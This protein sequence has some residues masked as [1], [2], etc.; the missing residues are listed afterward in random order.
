MIV[1]YV[2]RE[3]KGKLRKIE[4][5]YVERETARREA[6]KNSQQQDPDL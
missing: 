2:A 5:T 1:A 4:R 3:G 6:K